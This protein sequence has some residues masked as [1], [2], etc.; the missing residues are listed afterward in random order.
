MTPPRNRVR[1]ASID[2]SFLVIPSGS[3]CVTVAA[4][5]PSHATCH[6]VPPLQAERLR[7]R[8]HQV[9]AGASRQEREILAA[10]KSIE[11]RIRAEAGAIEYVVV[12]AAGVVCTPWPGENSAQVM[13]TVGFTIESWL[14][15]SFAAPSH[16]IR[17][18]CVPSRFQGNSSAEE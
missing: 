12:N 13:V 9:A 10:L 11:Y 17:S 2:P 4:R 15:E 3:D 14:A 18:E 8:G 1:S 7:R 5:D 6:S 16:S